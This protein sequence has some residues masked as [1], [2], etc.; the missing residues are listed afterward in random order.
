MKNYF[1][2]KAILFI[3]FLCQTNLLSA[4][5]KKEQKGDRLVEKYAYLAATEAYKQALSEKQVDSSA[6]AHKLASCYRKLNDPQ[7]MV[8]WYASIID[9][10][11]IESVDKYYY[12]Q[13][14]SS[15]GNYADSKFWFD[16]YLKEVPNDERAKKFSQTL[17]SLEDINSESE[18]F[19]LSDV[20]FNSEHS[21]FSPM[22]YG[23][24]LVFVSARNEKSKKHSWDDTRFLDLFYTSESDTIGFEIPKLFYSKINTRYHE[25]P[26][27]FYDHESK[28]VVTRNNYENRKLLKDNKGVTKLKLYFSSKDSLGNWSRVVPFKYNN[29]NYSVGHP[30]IT[31]DGQTL[32]FVSDKPAG[33]GG[34]D[35][36]VSKLKENGK[37]S[38]PQNLGEK[39]NTKGDEMFPF[40]YNNE[41]LYFSSNG[42]GGLGGLD[43]FIYD[44]S[45]QE[46]TNIGA[47]INSSRD[48]FGIILNEAGN[49]G[50]F[51]SN[52]LTEDGNDNIYHF[53]FEK[54]DFQELLLTVRDSVTSKVISDAKV[55]LEGEFIKES[56]IST[57]SLGQSRLQLALGYNYSIDISKE[58]Y[59]DKGLTFKNEKSTTALEVL[60]TRDCLSF[61]GEII[62]T[63]SN[64]NGTLL[65][66][67]DNATGE[68]QKLLLDDH[69]YS[70]CVEPYHSYKLKITN[71]Q[72][73]TKE[74]EIKIEDKPAIVKTEIVPIELGKSFKL[75]NIHYDLNKANIRKDAAIE[76]NKLVKILKDNPAI[77]IELG[78]HTDSRGSDSYNLKLS[79]RRAASAVK[80]IITQGIDPSRL[81]SKGYG[82]TQLINQCSNGISCSAEEHQANRRTEFK[83][84][85]IRKRIM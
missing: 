21:D 40:L 25:G 73:F 12:A 78:S 64:I 44:L 31:E 54:P 10:D 13:A 11:F 1:F 2:Y 30:T 76:L 49:E 50:Y 82:E 24:G 33:I 57:D 37:W 79:E 42:H 7:N 15:I 4:Q 9:S 43:V 48:D 27:A 81:S 45:S 60:L 66:L 46:I 23:E 6:V 61:E 16:V 52:R 63:T 58:S 55:H 84:L 14:L 71:D 75:E 70:F 34:T 38:K 68:V 39:I 72:F 80:Y 59:I 22:F 19:T 69:T 67:V 85:R 83:V 56:E 62:A 51:S 17:V 18:W 74:V 20:T 36:Y 53:T 29:D 32:Y 41:K 35:I 47:P 26:L 28:L 65:T 77:E 8:F 5:N 3:L